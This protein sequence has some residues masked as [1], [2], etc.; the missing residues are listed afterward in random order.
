MHHHSCLHPTYLAHLERPGA[1]SALTQVNRRTYNQPLSPPH[2]PT[3]F[4]PKNAAPSLV[5]TTFTL[6]QTQ[7][8]LAK[9]PHF[10]TAFAQFTDMDPTLSQMQSFDF[11]R[12]DPI[13]LE[14][15]LAYLRQHPDPP[16]EDVALL[17]GFQGL[18]A[19]AVGEQDWMAEPFQE[20]GGQLR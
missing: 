7:I 20:M 3:R 5:L 17:G 2:L 18:L 14:D 15:T 1:Q 4:A 6:R 19:D 8:A 10:Q 9:Q 11:D 13:A 12:L 16:A